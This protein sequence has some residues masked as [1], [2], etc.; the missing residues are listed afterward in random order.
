L[1]ILEGSGPYP[2]DETQQSPQDSL[3]FTLTDFQESFYI[4]KDNDRN[5]DL[6]FHEV[7]L[8]ENYLPAVWYAQQCADK[9][10]IILPSQWHLAPQIQMGLVLETAM[11]RAVEKGRPYLHEWDYQGRHEP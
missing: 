1:A 8:T 11:E 10:G 9:L 7:S 3:R 6:Y 2:G 5:T 4:I